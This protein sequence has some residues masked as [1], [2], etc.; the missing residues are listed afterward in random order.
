M[1]VS[2]NSSVFDPLNPNFG[3][4]SAPSAAYSPTA[5]VLNPYNLSFMS[6][7]VGPTAP[8]VTNSKSS[9]PS[10]SSGSSGS[11]NSNNS[12]GGQGPGGIVSGSYDPTKLTQDQR[13]W[14]W[15]QN[16]HNGTAP[17]GY[18]GEGGSSGDD[19]AAKAAQ[20]QQDIIN[21]FKTANDQY[22]SGVS[23][24]DKA[25]PFVMS[26][27]LAK[28][29]TNA[30]GKVS[31]YYDQLL[32][33][34]LTSVNYAK[35]NTIQDEQRLLTKLQADHDAYTGQTKADL[36][37]ALTSAGQEYGNAGSYDSGARNR[38]QGIQ[39]A[40][41]GYNLSAEQRNYEYN[42]NTAQIQ[43]NRT[44][45]QTIPLQLTQ[46]Q[47]EQQRNEATDIAATQAQN[48]NYDTAMNNYNRANAGIA[49]IAANGSYQSAGAFPGKT[50]AETSSALQSMLPGVTANTY[51]A[52]PLY[53]YS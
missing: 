46:Y 6:P 52:T 51:G 48:V 14:L 7:A 28:E 1:A 22:T 17:V 40:N 34:Y 25:H 2:L 23:A 53:A 33:N 26:D 50:S 43:A 49:N 10:K 29:A 20:M 4:F 21:A 24:Y 5:N 3:N 44:L 35:G 15:Q 37:T 30:A 11:S 12:G 36:E 32:N 19:Q 27:V 41:T 31:P 45:N 42:A 39:E 8:S 16:G 38:A 18:G 47:Q 9:T 13:Q